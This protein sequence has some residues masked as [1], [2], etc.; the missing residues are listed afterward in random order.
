LV[1][2]PRYKIEEKIKKEKLLIKKAIHLHLRNI[3]ANQLINQ[4]DM[5]M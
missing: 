3:K 5:L 1:K 4:K 2:V